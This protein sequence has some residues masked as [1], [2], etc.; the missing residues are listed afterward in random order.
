MNCRNCGAAM[1]LVASRGYYSCRYC[2]SFHFP[3]SV[4]GEGV[5]VVGPATR[6]LACPACNGPLAAAL[7]DEAHQVQY[8]GRCRGVLLPRSAFVDVITRRRSWAGE[9][10]SPPPPPDPK[11]LER[12][13]SC[14]G[15]TARM[16]THR[17]LGPGAVVIDSCE[18]CNLVWLDFGELRQI[19]N[20]PGRDRGSGSAGA[21]V[22]D[23]GESRPPDEVPDASGAGFLDFMLGTE[24]V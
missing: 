22:R 14:P 18:A 20:A 2:G 7:V 10:P 17:Y 21:P 11:E 15:C 23:T 13:V 5:R 1:E 19:V 3:D 16:D 6:P 9:P 8:C 4:T 24:D 12:A